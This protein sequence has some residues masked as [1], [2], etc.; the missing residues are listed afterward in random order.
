MV[1]NTLPETEVP[2]Q[3]QLDERLRLVS[4]LAT[5]A[6]LRAARIRPDMS[7]DDVVERLELVTAILERPFSVRH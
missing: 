4:D 2:P 3:P 1:M 7:V 6:F 5:R